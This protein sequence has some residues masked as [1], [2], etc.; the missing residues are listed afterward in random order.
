[1]RK[2]WLIGIVLCTMLFV[3]ACSGSKTNSNEGNNESG[4]PSNGA[5]AANSNAPAAA[6]EKVDPYG[7]YDSPL[8]IKIAQI[9]PP[10]DKGLPEGQTLEDNAM[11]KFYED[12]LN[13]KL[14]RDWT[15]VQ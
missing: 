3:S 7:K 4:T 13:I 9:I 8:T 12:N 11:T 15:A 6:D 10:G 2:K 1:M 5:N 14:Q